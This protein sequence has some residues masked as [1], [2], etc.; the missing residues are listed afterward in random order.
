MGETHS[1]YYVL[2]QVEDRPG[3]LAEIAA[4]F[5][6]HGVSI[7]HVWQEGLGDD[8]QL[9]FITHSAQDAS[10]QASVGD[11]EG[12]ASVEAVQGVLRVEGEE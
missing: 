3:V 11:L 6:S 10:L 12:L 9:V 5:G 1:E 7:R 2:L 4:V 8:A